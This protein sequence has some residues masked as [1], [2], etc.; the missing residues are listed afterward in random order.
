[1]VTT[2]STPLIAGWARLDLPPSETD[3][4]AS[5][6]EALTGLRVPS[7]V[8]HSLLDGFGTFAFVAVDDGDR[9]LSVTETYGPE[10]EWTLLDP[11]RFASAIEGV[12]G[13][14]ARLAGRVIARQDDPADLEPADA[15]EDA[16]A[17]EEDDA[18]AD[19]EDDANRVAV[20]LP[21]SLDALVWTTHEKD[22]VLRMLAA[23]FDM[24]FAAADAGALG[25][26]ITP[27]DGGDRDR[28]FIDGLWAMTD[29]IAAWQSRGEYGASFVRGKTA[30]ILSWRSRATLVD[31][32]FPNQ[33]IDGEQTIA[34]SLRVL[35][36]ES[37]PTSWVRRFR[38]TGEQATA[39]RA[40]AR[41]DPQPG[42]IR[43]LAT[44]L[45]LPSQF[46]DAFE[47]EGGVHDAA[48]R[49]VIEPQ[50]ARAQFSE[51]MRTEI[52]G[53]APDAGT[54]QR[55]HPRAWLLISAVGIVTLATF[56]II[57]VASGRLIAAIPGIIAVLW[58]GSLL[59]ARAALR[60]R[61]AQDAGSDRPAHDS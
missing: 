31:P 42:M 34:D 5:L 40:L 45:D 57:G 52:A 10:I 55:R 47:S 56:S 37:D 46:S 19:E 48:D 50:S 61:Q 29:G 54:F 51:A 53:A 4:V 32:S 2:D 17:D 26:M 13:R 27:H 8:R 39:L 14:G 36:P 59:V 6:A 3:L 25:R 15:D 22:D 43:E 41:R 44:I 21:R 11:R 16:D 9:V 7:S 60:A 12:A 20:D 18:D 35:T 49:I 24:S 33:T 28:A 30:E 58:A 23:R 38:L 1:M